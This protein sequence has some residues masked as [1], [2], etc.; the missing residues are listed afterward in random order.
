MITEELILKINQIRKFVTNH[1]P[2]I[3]AL[4]ESVVREFLSNHLPKSVSV[5]S[6]FIL[7]ENSEISRQ[8]DII[9]WDSLNYA[10]IYQNKDIVIVPKASIKC[11]IEVKTT[12]NKSIFYSAVDYFKSFKFSHSFKTYLF[13]VNSCPDN[14]IGKYLI[15]FDHPGEYKQWDHDTF[16]YLPD[17]IIGLN[18][19]F[20]MAKD[21]I[22]FNSDY[23]G[24]TSRFYKNKEGSEISAIQIFLISIYEQIMDYQNEQFKQLNDRSNFEYGRAYELFI[25]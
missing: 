25:I 12:M 7:I 22:P 1:N 3:G 19:S 10:P 14:Q 15:E 16:A 23:Y 4:T 17:E 24:F 6:G 2:S 13:I 21:L 11:V 20:N 18:T 9:I 8:C 5:S